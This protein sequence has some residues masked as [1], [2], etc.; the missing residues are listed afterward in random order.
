LDGISGIRNAGAIIVP[1]SL[2][3]RLSKIPMSNVGAVLPVTDGARLHQFTGQTAINGE[4]LANPAGGPDDVLVVTGQLAVTSPVQKV[5]FGQVIVTGQIVA[6]EGS[7]TALGAGISSLTGQV[8]YYPYSEG[9][10]VRV[11]IGSQHISGRS[12]ANPAGKETDILLVIGDLVVTS[13]VEKLGYQHIVAIGPVLAPLGSEEALEGRI[14]SIGEGVVYYTA[15]PR[16]FTGKDT[17]TRT[18]FEYLD[19]PITLVLT[20][21][22]TFDAD[23]TVDLLKDKLAGVVLT[24]K[25]MAPRDL[26]G[27]VQART[28]AKSGLIAVSDA[29]P[30]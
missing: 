25:L 3:A 27:I 9:A 26:V 11:Q 10:A 12:L 2:V 16:V 4:A 23:V 24:G 13:P 1:R 28:L 29:A 8:M 5:G 6:P 22:F 19:E 7:E 21:S 14:V 18:F 17:F 20:G 30:A 15:P